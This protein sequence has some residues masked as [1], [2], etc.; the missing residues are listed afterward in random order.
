[1]VAE[2]IKS[3]LVALFGF[4]IVLPHMFSYI[5]SRIAGRSFLQQQIG[6]AG[7]PF[8]RSFNNKIVLIMIVNMD[9]GLAKD[10]E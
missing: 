4:K 3:T 8:H 5:T 9:T 10:W 1:M 2:R 7:M 6:V